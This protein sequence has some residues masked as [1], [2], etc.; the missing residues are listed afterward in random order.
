MSSVRSVLIY[1]LTQIK[2]SFRDRSA[3]F[4]TVLFPL[5]FLVIFGF[6][7]GGNNAG[8]SN[9]NIAVINQSKT[10]FSKEFAKDIGKNKTFK[11]V[12]VS[13]LTDAKSKM[14][15]NSL[16]SIIVL[17]AGFGKL[18]YAI[19]LSTETS[20]GASIAMD[21]SG[22]YAGDGYGG[23]GK[24]P[25]PTIPSGQVQVYY[26]KASPT[27]GQTV[28]AIMSGT[29]SAINAKLIGV[30]PLSVQQKSVDVADLSPFSF[31]FSG[32]FAFSLMS[33]TIMGLG[34]QLPSEKKTG[35]LRRVEVTPFQPWQM[36]VGSV[37]AYLVL[38]MVSAA[39]FTIAG[40]LLFHFQM[41]GSWLVLAIFSV[42]SAFVMAGFG[43]I[44]AGWAR[45]QQQA[46]PITMAIAYPLMFLSGV[47]IPRFMMPTWLQKVGEW[48]PMSPV[49]DG[50]RFITTQNYSFI[51]LAPQLGMLAVWGVIAYIIA[52]LVFRW[53]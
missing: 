17:P 2:R 34:Q 1:A 28:A 46:M 27:T 8:S 51:K 39:I 48:T 18:T 50:V 38:T 43:M 24:V 31:I 29:L 20:R 5:I 19:S 4:F 52:F 3:L 30:P 22:A 23:S 41:H 21:Y 11:V 12:A 13:S 45:N 42:L 25:S 47:F 9:F 53:E 37:L 6:I 32:L 15:Q 35:A 33:M 14:N 16:D 40:I 7:Y 44:V 49:V 36:I 26:S 10:A